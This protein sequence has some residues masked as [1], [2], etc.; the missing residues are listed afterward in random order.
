MPLSLVLYKSTVEAL[1]HL[2]KKIGLDI[3]MRDG[4]SAKKKVGR[5]SRLLSSTPSTP[6][7]L[8]VGGERLAPLQFMKVELLLLS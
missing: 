2:E 7:L 3:S 4:A 8:R 1:R 5:A 6:L